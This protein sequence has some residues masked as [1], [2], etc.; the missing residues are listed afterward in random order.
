[1]ALLAPLSNILCRHE[2]YWSERHLADRCRRCGLLRSDD[3]NPSEG[4][5]PE[6]EIAVGTNPFAGSAAERMDAVAWRRPRTPGM[7]I[8]EA[9]SAVQLRHEAE[10]RRNLLL[11]WLKT[12]SEG[13]PLACEAALGL[14]MALIEDAHSADP[15]VFGPRAAE[16]FASLHE[17]K[18]RF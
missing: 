4:E 15:L 10:S 5:L 18:T 8:P 17:A 11:G 16:Y 9:I 7:D 2:F 3:Q 13:Q 6:A 1:M 14:A 12:L